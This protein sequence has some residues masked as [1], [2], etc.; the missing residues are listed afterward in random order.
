[1]SS[2]SAGP[3]W[4]FDGIEI[5]PAG[6][7]LHRDGVEQALEPKA[8]A[9]LLLLAAEPGRAFE[10]DAILDA[11]WGHRHVTPGTLNRIITL[12]RHALGESAHAPRYLHTVHGVGYRLDAVIERR[13]PRDD[14]LPAQAVP[15]APTMD[16]ATPPAGIASP[17]PASPPRER[18]RRALPLLL[19]AGALLL[20][21]AWWLR[22]DGAPNVAPA[23]PAT[24]AAAT[25]PAAGAP[26]AAPVLA[27]LPLRTLGDD[28]RSDEF[29]DGLSEELIN[30]LARLEG[31]QVTSRTSSFQFR[32]DSLPLAEVARK[33]G[34]THVL[35]G[36]VREDGE[37]LRIAL[38]LVDATQD[39][40]LWSERYDRSFGDIFSIQDDIARA[41]GETL[42]L[43]LGLAPS[44]LGR[45]E[46]PALYRRYLQARRAYGDRGDRAADR[47]PALAMMRTLVQ[48]HPDYA[49]AWG[50][51][52]AFSWATSVYDIAQRP[53]L[54]QEAEA[55]AQ[56]A[57]AL[58]PEQPDAL[59]VTASR[60]C[61]ERRWAD[62]L[63]ASR[64][65]VAG[66]PSDAI[67]RSGHAARLATLGY[68]SEAL[69]EL[70][71]GLALDPLSQRLHTVR[72]RI[73]DTLGRHEEA[74]EHLQLAGAEAAGQTSNF[75]NAVWRGD[76]DEAEQLARALGPRVPWR[77]SQLATVAALRDPARWPEV[78]AAIARAEQ[79]IVEAAIGEPYD[80]NRWFLPQRDYAR[81]VEYLDR[82]SRQG[83]ATY[84]WIFWMPRE[85]ALR[86][87]PAFA[88]WVRDS[89]RLAFWREAGWPDACRSDGGDGFTCD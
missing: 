86:R 22:R 52:A 33:L 40:M 5:D 13:E 53:A 29:A 67:W 68:V 55:A 31:L 89:G 50:G 30:L 25:V 62:C 60:A 45:N 3:L 49:R 41:V 72:A 39:R 74:F 18:F 88:Q 27:V 65:A 63:D 69:R 20:V 2:N 79:R 28:A 1:M 42:Q 66:A 6:R 44:S 26:R 7:R 34:A 61:R 21:S 77:E 9:V 10:R 83:Y 84:Q 16:T 51:L 43:R 12:L 47:K 24:T 11:V 19:A 57:L 17:A 8:F 37:R 38:R 59:A 82:I 85:A 87:S 23:D 32:D 81:D 46:D 76:L 64:R 75:Y 48:E 80:F 36:S 14:A 4:R 78:E 56:R 70:D 15:P 58:D 35:E 73:L 54:Q 71:R